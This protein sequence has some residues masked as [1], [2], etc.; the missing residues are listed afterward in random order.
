MMRR[1]ISKCIRDRLRHPEAHDVDA[2]LLILS[3]GPCIA[4]IGADRN[5]FHFKQDC[6]QVKIDIL[7]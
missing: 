4:P 3:Q 2:L 6:E 7:K 5:A 1:T